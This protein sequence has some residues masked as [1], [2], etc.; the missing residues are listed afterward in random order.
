MSKFIVIEGPDACGKATQAKMIKK[1]LQSI[2][3]KVA[4]FEVPVDD[5]FTYKII[6][7]M[8]ENGSAK[9]FPK[10]FQKIQAFNRLIF[11]S[12]ILKSYEEECDFLIFDRWSLSST[13]YGLAFGLEKKFVD[14]L[15][16]KTRAPDHTIVLLGKSHG[17]HAE[18][19]YE[20]DV[21]LQEKVNV[22]YLDWANEH[23]NE[24]S[25]IN[26]NQEREEVFQQI[27]SSL[28][29]KGFIS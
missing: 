12:T 7:W 13:I 29:K 11:Q 14:K 6:Y 17:K 22:L 16:A 18:D 2:G 9:M 24:C 5:G 8:L 19:E 15:Y 3:Y 25:V 23:S 4:S 20:S 10:T 21:K 28:E 1:Y 27:R 26:C